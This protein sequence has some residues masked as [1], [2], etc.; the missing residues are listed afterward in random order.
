MKER[1]KTL[2]LF[3]ILYLVLS[4]VNWEA[5][6]WPWIGG[7]APFKTDALSVLIVEETEQRTPAIDSLAGTIEHAVDVAKG[8]HRR[9]DK[10]Q[11]DLS[12]DEPW[13]AE[14]WKAKGATVP[15]IVAA[16]SRR[17]VSQPLTTDSLKAL[18]ILGVK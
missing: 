1:F 14:A 11:S 3:A 7:K 16:D 12:L 17:G 5:W 18:S 9:L 6:T 8:K 2:I 4:S 15:W 13:V 10:D